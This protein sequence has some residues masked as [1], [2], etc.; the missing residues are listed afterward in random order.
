[1]IELTTFRLTSD[2]DEPQFRKADRKVQVEFAYHQPGLLRRTTAHSTD[3]G[4]MVIEIWR[5]ER[6]ADACLR[7]RPAEVA[8]A[9][10]LSSIDPTTL[11]TTRYSTL[12]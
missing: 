8:T 7:K 4:W 11:R 12:D 5:S 6:E 1:M 2:A 10:F 9:G 3:G